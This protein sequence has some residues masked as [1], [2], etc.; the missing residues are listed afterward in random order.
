MWLM[1]TRQDSLVQGCHVYFS[2][3]ELLL[4]DGKG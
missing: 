1:G 3:V 2:H 4:L